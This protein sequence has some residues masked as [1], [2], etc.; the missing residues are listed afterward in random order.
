MPTNA[1]K[2]FLEGF[3]KKVKA[4][5]KK[6]SL[7]SKKDKVLV[8]VSGGKDST[9]ALYLL[10]KFGYAVEAI[11]IDVLIGKYTKDNLENIKKFC[12]ESKIRL[13]VVSFRKK[14][15]YSV[16]Y[17]KSALKSKGAGLN[18]C[19]V[20]GVLRRYLINKHVKKLGADKVVTGHNLDDEAESVM[21]NFFRNT[22]HLSARLGPVSG[23]AKH[24][25]FVPRVKPLYFTKKSDVEKYS[26]IMNFPVQY[27]ACPCSVDAYRRS[28]REFLDALEKENPQIKENIISNFLAMLPKLKLKFKAQSPNICRKC[29]EPSMSDECRTCRILA[30]L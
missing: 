12:K 11:T 13:H 16:C 8:A 10:K 17:M 29:G 4:T 6:Y 2:R 30:S 19:T 1:E 9:T 28:V 23:F 20:C 18:S 24:A 26:K 5:I 7:L 3:E 15:G 14:F 27:G 22:M 25:G 21:M